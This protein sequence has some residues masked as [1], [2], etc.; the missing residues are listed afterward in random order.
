ML[1]GPEKETNG[2]EGLNDVEK[3]FAAAFEGAAAGGVGDRKDTDDN[4]DE[5]VKK[6]EEGKGDGEE[7][8]KDD[9]KEESAANDTSGID[10]LKAE[11]E[12]LK[13]KL[14]DKEKPEEKKEEQ[15]PFDHEIFWNNVEN[16]FPDDVK[17]LFKEKA[18]DFDEILQMQD[19]K[20]KVV[21]KRVVNYMHGVFG[22]LG[23]KI[24]KPVLAEF[25][26]VMQAEH[27]RT[28]KDEHPDYLSI[29]DSGKLDKW[30]TSLPSTE[31]EK[32]KKI[33]EQGSAEEVI[34]MITKYKEQN[35]AT[36]PD[37]DNVVKK[38]SSAGPPIVPKDN[39]KNDFDATWE[40]AKAARKS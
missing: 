37:P 16:E 20:T 26:K 27:V 11:I 34:G 30:V 9:Q 31:K 4:T 38:K 3:A 13:K 22:D 10:D 15:T 2:M 14:E 36:E 40:E 6:E 33:M 17:E 7:E 1:N 18:E 39:G 12:E 24:L 25:Q 35:K 21:M 23:E 32:M 28:I 19:A 5:G 29:K 8:K